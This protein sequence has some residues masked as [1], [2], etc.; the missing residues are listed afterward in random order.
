MNRSFPSHKKYWK[1]VETND[2]TIA[3]NMLYVPH[4]SEKQSHAYISK[5]NSMFENQAILV[6]TNGEK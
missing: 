5:H 1:K 2:K 4:K 3:L 6:I